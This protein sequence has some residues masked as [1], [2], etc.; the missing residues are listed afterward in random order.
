MQVRRTNSLAPGCGEVKRALTSPAHTTKGTEERGAGRSG[1]CRKTPG[2]MPSKRVWFNHRLCVVR[3]TLQE[4]HADWF[5]NSS[6]QARKLNLLIYLSSMTFSLIPIW[7]FTDFPL[8]MAEHAVE[9]SQIIHPAFRHT[10]I[11]SVAY[12]MLLN[13]VVYVAQDIA[14]VI[15]A[16]VSPVTYSIASASLFNR[17]SIMCI[18]LVWFNQNVH[19]IQS[20]GT[21]L[22]FLCLW[23][24]NTAKGEIARVETRGLGVWALHSSRP[25]THR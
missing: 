17:F 20:V 8:L 4:D 11:H 22:A 23:I 9:R 25:R 7:A 24:Y 6:P 2:P 21:T 3:H 5:Q 1:R 18:T 14:F 15:L 12:Y 16:S 10:A 13:G 19:P